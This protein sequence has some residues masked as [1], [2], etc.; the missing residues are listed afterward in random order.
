LN[1]CVSRLLLRQ[2]YVADN[3]VRLMRRE[4]RCVFFVLTLLPL[5]YRVKSQILAHPVFKM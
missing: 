5:A 4:M 1:S 3:A 2:K